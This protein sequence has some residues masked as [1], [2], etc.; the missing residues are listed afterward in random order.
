MTLAQTQRELQESKAEAD[1]L[2]KRLAELETKQAV[3]YS[4]SA[5]TD[6]G[7]KSSFQPSRAR[8]LS[9]PPP[10]KP[11]SGSASASASPSSAL[12]SSAVS[13]TPQSS[14]QTPLP[15]PPFDERKVVSSPNNT[16][17]SNSNSNSAP[18]TA[19]SNEFS[20]PA[21][22]GGNSSSSSFLSPNRFYSLTQMENESLASHMA[23]QQNAT[24]L[25]KPSM[26][27]VAGGSTNHS[28]PASAGGNVGLSHSVPA[29]AGGN[30]GLSFDSQGNSFTPAGAGES[31][32]FSAQAS[33]GGNFG[34]GSY[35]P[36]SF[37]PSLFV[38]GPFVPNSNAP[39][40]SFA[41]PG[42]VSF[43][44]PTGVFNSPVAGLSGPPAGSQFGLP[45]AGSVANNP[46]WL[47]GMSSKNV[48]P[49][50]LPTPFTGDGKEDVVAWLYSVS[51]STYGCSEIDRVIF[52]TQGLRG[53]ALQWLQSWVPLGQI[54]TWAQFEH[55]ITIRFTRIAAASE[56]YLAFTR[57][58]QGNNSVSGFVAE[59]NSVCQ[60]VERLL[61]MLPE[62]VKLTHFVQGL[63]ARARQSVITSGTGSLWQ[64]QMIACQMEQYASA[65]AAQ[66]RTSAP[67]LRARVAAVTDDM[68]EE[69]AAATM[70]TAR[71]EHRYKSGCW[72]CEAPD[73]MQAECP[74]RCLEEACKDAYPHAKHAKGTPAPVPARGGRGGSRGGRGGSRGGS[75][76]NRGGLTAAGKE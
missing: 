69:V 60:R 41:L 46:M 5:Q 31:A 35:V 67:T 40:P 32:N 43:A 75:R 55:A 72:L 44:L 70:N 39:A 38:P 8:S 30:V 22:A 13:R 76:G 25:Q 9:Q 1:V 20:T 57:T 49:R 51:V 36:S 59:F 56:A 42:A 4:A 68:T 16:F 71:R 33:A 63:A 65:F 54:P 6:S 50:G 52:A 12:S 18:A 11:E 2:R 34:L 21:S 74:D 7:A 61:G 53:S 37:A 24:S 73:H 48:K 45:V 58:E 29:S 17:V 26:P 66:S 28:V 3:S 15:H 14:A 10:L 47:S 27:A 19:G 64:A 62:G 23:E